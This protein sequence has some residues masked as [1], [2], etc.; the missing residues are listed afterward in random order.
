[1]ETQGV[2]E[3]LVSGLTFQQV[4]SMRGD[5][6][7]PLYSFSCC[8]DRQG[9]GELIYDRGGVGSYRQLLER[10]WRKDFIPYKKQAWDHLTNVLSAGSFDN[11]VRQQARAAAYTVAAV[12]ELNLRHSDSLA[13]VL[14]EVGLN[15]EANALERTVLRM[16]AGESLH[17]YKEGQNFVVLTGILPPQATRSS[18]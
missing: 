13:E 18:A 8:L 5:V 17:G 12:Y 9:F 7:R 6:A 1:M 10:L 3:L 11:S 4:E 16:K 14:H 15:R 2:S